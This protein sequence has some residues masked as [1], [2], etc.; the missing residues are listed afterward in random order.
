MGLGLNQGALSVVRYLHAHKALI[1]VTDLRSKKKLQQ[2]LNR[3]RDLHEITYI[4]GRHRLRDF[5]SADLIF[6]NPDVPSTSLY[7][8]EAKKKQNSGDK[9]GRFFY[10]TYE[11]NRDWHNRNKG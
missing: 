4:L 5:R 1:T 3:L 7:L 11:G 6:R 9:R 2:T 10:G 8:K